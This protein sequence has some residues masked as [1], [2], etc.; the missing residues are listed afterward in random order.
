MCRTCQ[1]SPPPA[2]TTILAVCSQVLCTVMRYRN[3]FLWDP[4][5]LCRSPKGSGIGPTRLEPKRWS[6]ASQDDDPDSDSDSDADEKAEGQFFLGDSLWI[7]SE[8]TRTHSTLYCI[9]TTNL[10]Q[11]FQHR[12]T[13]ASSLFSFPSALLSAVGQNLDFQKRV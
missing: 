1:S 12:I 3:T 6:F 9:I 8:T 5:A 13:K 4:G 2:V 10:I 7:E 11:H